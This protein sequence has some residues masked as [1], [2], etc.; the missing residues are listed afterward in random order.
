MLK[1]NRPV[2]IMRGEHP[3]EHFIKI[4]INDGPKIHARIRKTESTGT[5]LV[6]RKGRPN[7]P[8]I[9]PPGHQEAFIAEM[10]RMAREQRTDFEVRISFTSDRHSAQRALAGWLRTAYLVA[11]AAFGYRYVFGPGLDVIREQIQRCDERLIPAFHVLVPKV[12]QSA[13]HLVIGNLQ[14][15]I[16]PIIVQIGWHAVFLPDVTDTTFYE[17]FDAYRRNHPERCD[18]TGI[19][20]EWPAHPVYAVD[21]WRRY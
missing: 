17:R 3:Q 12:A 13:R 6:G 5:L 7:G 14:D 20:L 16:R 21:R 11:F 1:A 10:E 4:G 18:W 9:D 2:S 19:D 8:P 15:G